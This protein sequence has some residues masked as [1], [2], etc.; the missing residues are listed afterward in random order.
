VLL[1]IVFSSLF[2]STQASLPNFNA[3]LS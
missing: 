3:A 2:F 1:L